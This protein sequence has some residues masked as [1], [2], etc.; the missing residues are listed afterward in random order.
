MATNKLI[1]NSTEEFMAAYRP[2][3]NPLY[4][5]L[6]ARSKQYPL[7]MGSVKMTKSTAVGDIR[8]K[9]I[10]PKD[11]ILSQITVSS[12]SKSFKKYAF[13]NQYIQSEFQE[14][15]D[16]DGI[17]AQVL[18]EHQKQF[19]EIT[20]LGDG[21]AANN[22]INNGL[23]WSGDA[24]YVLNS[25]AAI[26]ASPNAQT[27]LYAKIQE[28]LSAAREVSGPKAIVLYGATTLS[29]YDSLM[30]DAETSF[31]SVLKDGLEVSET[32]IRMP[33]DITPSS[34]NGFIVISL[35][36][37]MFH[38]LTLPK[39]LNNGV[40]EEK[41]HSWHNFVIGSSMV[42]VEAPGA[43]IRQPLTFS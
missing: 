7:E 19:D 40:N 38:Y 24:N 37:V 32:V 23:Y 4:G 26:S 9:R 25:S 33:K 21:T 29:T 17:V 36:E 12:G 28:V 16:I 5:L 35:D 34:S 1:V 6:L 27:S 13:G 10:T 8:A 11:N 22:V 41:L 42:E 14:A 20:L 18:D 31:K 3:Y 2:K 39:V 43:I 15:G 30:P